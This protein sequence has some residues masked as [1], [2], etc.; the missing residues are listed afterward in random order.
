MGYSFPPNLDNMVRHWMKVGAY[1]SEDEVLL[2]AM[3]ALE[4]VQKREN[5]L[6]REVHR[7]LAKAGGGL[8]LPLDRAEFKA[9]ARRRF[10]D[11]GWRYDGVCHLSSRSWAKRVPE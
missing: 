9:E 5:E 10:A 7:R 6:R 3:L 4:D 2:D 1:A 8:S 11:P